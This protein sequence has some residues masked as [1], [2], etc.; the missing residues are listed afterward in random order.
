MPVQAQA[1]PVVMAGHDLVATAQTGTGKTLGFALPCLSRL[2]QGKLEKNMMLVMVP[3]RELAVQVH[4]VISEYGQPLNLR[5]TAIYGGVGMGPQFQ[6]L[7]RGV[8]VIVATPGRLLD[9]MQQGSIEFKSLKM[10]V[11]DEADRMLDM[12]F[13]PDIRRI[14]G[15]LPAKRQTLMFSATFA[16]EIGKLAKEMLNDPKRIAIGVSTKPVETVKQVVYPVTTEDKSEL[17]L[18]ILDQEKP[19]SVLVFMRTRFRTDR[20]GKM[21]KNAKYSVAVIHGNRTQSQRQQGLDGFKRGRY[22]I[23][24]A[25]DVAAR[26]LDVDGISHVINFDIPDTADAYIHRIGRT[27]RAQATGDAITFV[28]PEDRHILFDIEKT[29]GKPLPKE[30][31]EKAPDISFTPRSSRKPTSGPRGGR[32]AN[33]DKKKSTTHPNPHRFSSRGESSESSRFSG[34]AKPRRSWG[35]NQKKRGSLVKG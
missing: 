29:I 13:L 21:L 34:S 12:G 10:L 6:A 32:F 18:K 20:I 28:A 22:Q 15:Q 17:L 5:A 23:L 14:L 26:G 3:T 9:H 2:S 19:E 31:W 33:G 27:G 16:D 25:T 4:S 35:G 30:M 8:H 11:I 7:R 1:I 24:V